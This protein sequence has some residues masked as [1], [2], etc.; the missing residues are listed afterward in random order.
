MTEVARP[1][2]NQLLTK[3]E[4]VAR[5]IR[6]GIVAGRLAPGQRLLQNQLADELGVSQ[7]PVREALRGLVTEGWL[8]R[9]SHI[10]VSVAEI[11]PDG[12]D[13][14]YRLRALLEGDLAAEAAARVSNDL[15]G[16]IGQLNE[17]YRQAVGA[18]DTAAARTANFQFHAAIWAGANSPTAVSLVNALWARV[19]R[20]T[21]SD[22]QRGRKTIAEHE[23]VI[24]G[25]AS[26]DPERARAALAGHI[27]SGQQDYHRA[28]DPGR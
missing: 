23:N 22:G 1:A 2:G 20:P 13:E 14:I 6:E 28:F 15:L 21:A 19:P 11:N 27:R 17:T 9:E 25:L 4:L 3:E 12:V 24:A 16:E 7:T 18:N 26:A 10:G 8:V 5:H